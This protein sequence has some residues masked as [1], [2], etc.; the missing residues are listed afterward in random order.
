[1]TC[2]ECKGELKLTRKTDKGKWFNV[3]KCGK[4][5]YERLLTPQERQDFNG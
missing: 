4:C 3:F 2:P 1:M 5:G